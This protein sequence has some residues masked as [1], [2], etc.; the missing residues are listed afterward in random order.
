MAE[1]S[2]P[3]V[4][5]ALMWKDGKVLSV[6]RKDDRTSYGLPGGKVDPGETLE[7]ALLREVQEETGVQIKRFEAEPVFEA[8]SSSGDFYSYTF[9]VYEWE[10]EPHSAEAGHVCWADP[11]LLAD[12][13]QQ[14]SPYNSALFASLGVVPVE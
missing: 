8:H 7:D 13:R 1:N 6:S 4:V 14:F 3:K 5:L 12:K 11:K 2:K 9:Y 10:G